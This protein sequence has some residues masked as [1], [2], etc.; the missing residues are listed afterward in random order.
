M[1][2]RNMMIGGAGATAPGAPTG[3]SAGSQTETTMSVSFSAPANNGGSAIT[4]FTVT[5]SPGGLTASGASSPL[6]VTGLTGSTSYTFTVTATNAIG[7]SPAS[8]PSSAVTTSAPFSLA[9]FYA[10][11]SF[12]TQTYNGAGGPT[13]TINTFTAPVSGSYEFELAGGE[14]GSPAGGEGS[15]NWPGGAGDGR[16]CIIKYNIQAGDTIYSVAGGKA[17]INGSGN[18]ANGGGG[19]GGGSFVWN[20]VSGSKNLIAAA[21]GGG[22]Q[23]IFNESGGNPEFCNGKVG[24]NANNGTDDQ[25]GGLTAGTGGGDS[26]LGVYSGLTYPSKGW[27][28]MS[29]A[30]NFNGRDGW[31][32]G[33]GGFG[34]GG[35]PADGSH[36]GGGGGGYSGGGCGYFGQRNGG[37][38]NP[39]RN[40]GG[41]GGSYSHPSA[42]SSN[43]NAGSKSG[44]GYVIIRPAT[45]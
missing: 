37:T 31:Y 13:G 42:R 6:T 27:N 10:G 7:T 15:N 3:V 35:G 24:N 30:N 36:A 45:S 32:A 40:G 18:Y 34:G 8:S 12:S 26:V 5:S 1:S 41:G 43:L 4:S 20:I 25:G 22:G 29:A 39:N 17:A 14:G 33:Y 11:T 44:E 38:G 28:S 2:I 21:G 16:T 23:S 9:T 19:G